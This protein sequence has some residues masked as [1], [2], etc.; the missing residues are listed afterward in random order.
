MRIDNHVLSAIQVS[1]DKIH[2]QESIILCQSVTKIKRSGGRSKRFLV[3]TQSHFSHYEPKAFQKEAKLARR[4][5]WDSFL[6]LSSP[7][8]DP[9]ITH[10]YFKEKKVTIFAEN[11]A[12]IITEVVRHLKTL[13]TP[14][15]FSMD[16]ITVSA[17]LKKQLKR[18]GD[19][20]L[21]RLHFKSYVLNRP[22]SHA[23][24]L[25]LADWLQGSGQDVFDLGPFLEFRSDLDLIFDALL[26]SRKVKLLRCPQ[27]EGFSVWPYL[28]QFYCRGGHIPILEIHGR[29]TAAEFEEFLDNLMKAQNHC[30]HG[31]HFCDGEF[32][33]PFMVQFAILIECCVLSRVAFS[34]RVSLEG[35]SV[36]TNLLSS[37]RGFQHVREL[38]LV[39]CPALAPATV[40]ASLPSLRLWHWDDSEVEVGVFMNDLCS[41]RTCELEELVL[42]NGNAFTAVK[43]GLFLPPK[44]TTLTITGIAWELGTLESLIQLCGSEGPGRRL[45][46]LDLSDARLLNSEWGSVD[47]F[48]ATLPL[49]RLV[50]LAWDNNPIG[51]GFVALLRRNPAL[52]ALS[53]NYCPHGMEVVG[54]L[55]DFI[56]GSSSLSALSLKGNA[57]VNFCSG[58]EEVMAG[59]YNNQTIV[60]LDVSGNHVGD[61][62]LPIIGSLLSQHPTLS[63]IA[64]DGNDITSRDDLG[65]LFGLV[66]EH[67]RS[68][69]L[70]F[71]DSDMERQRA[72]G[73]I[74]EK[75]VE[76]FRD[77]CLACLK[78][79]LSEVAEERP[80]EAP[81]DMTPLDIV[82][83]LSGL[84]TIAI[85]SLLP[86]SLQAIV[87]SVGEAY[88][89]EGLWARVS[90][91]EPPVDTDERLLTINELFAIDRLLEAIPD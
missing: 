16:S 50:S 82:G 32:D 38:S 11:A 41:L 30:L 74:T 9:L 29:P 62:I 39:G 40:L 45:L 80:G 25:F 17:G 36:F 48:L 12:Q 69:Q 90:L 46:S 84:D 58:M 79:E 81:A 27:T 65:G 83:I 60:A 28:G 54:P 47:G 42:K 63:R 33:T 66:F 4:F 86:E 56:V 22:F 67:P 49:D 8:D 55:S 35:L 70:Q 1:P 53:I 59:I 3:L 43:D 89:S 37:V 19:G 20:F 76:K 77:E 5:C 24:D 10:F 75:D 14:A 21:R 68:I 64:L 23:L 52:T 51:E 73:V 15:E 2:Y 57:N 44:L 18:Y 71:P 61:S 85:E 31:V 88:V 72:M 34:N 91:V 78:P 13:F 6:S 7:P 26:A 87:H